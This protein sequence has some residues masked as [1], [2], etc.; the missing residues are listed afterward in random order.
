MVTVGFD[1]VSMGCRGVVWRGRDGRGTVGAW[2][3]FGVGDVTDALYSGNREEKSQCISSGYHWRGYSA[4]EMMDTR[5]WNNIDG[6]HTFF[7]FT[8]EA[9]YGVP[10][11]SC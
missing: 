8:E 9:H 6:K 2:G 11:C 5:D 3:E 4:V 7:T 1:G 10:R